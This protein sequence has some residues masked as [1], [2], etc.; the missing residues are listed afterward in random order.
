MLLGIY[1]YQVYFSKFIRCLYDGYQKIF[2]YPIFESITVHK[3]LDTI[4]S[5]FLIKN[6][7][8]DNLFLKAALDLPFKPGNFAP[9]L[10]SRPE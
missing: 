9:G 3:P 2:I 5:L 1:S 4:E 7:T 6:F 8:S 10:I